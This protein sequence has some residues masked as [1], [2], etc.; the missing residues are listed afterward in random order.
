MS[1]GLARCMRAAAELSSLLLL[2]PY[3]CRLCPEIQVLSNQRGGRARK[4]VVEPASN[5][6]PN[7]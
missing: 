4:A 6:L 5:L 3:V 7:S 2:E 1:L